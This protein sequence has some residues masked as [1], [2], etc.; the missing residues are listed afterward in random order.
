M[1][2]TISRTI[3]MFGLFIVM[4]LAVNVYAENIVPPTS[5][6]GIIGGEELLCVLENDP[7]HPNVMQIVS[8]TG[9]LST[10][11]TGSMDFK[12]SQH[13]VIL[14]DVALTG[15]SVSVA[16]KSTGEISF[17][18][19]GKESGLAYLFPHGRML[20]PLTLG[21]TL[22]NFYSVTPF[23][24]GAL[25]L[26][27][28]SSDRQKL[29]ATLSGVFSATTP[30]IGKAFLR[31]SFSCNHSK[32]KEIVKHAIP[33]LKRFT[34]V[35]IETTQLLNQALGQGRVTVPVAPDRGGIIHSEITV[36]PDEIIGEEFQVV[37]LNEMGEFEPLSVTLPYT[38]RSG[39]AAFTLTS[40]AAV[41]L[42]PD[43][44][45]SLSALEPLEL[46]LSLTDID[47]QEAY[48]VLS[49]FNHIVYNFTGLDYAVDV[50]NDVVEEPELVAE[51]EV[52]PS[53]IIVPNFVSL[54]FLTDKEQLER[55]GR[56]PGTTTVLDRFVTLTSTL[57]QFL[58]TIVGCWEPGTNSDPCVVNHGPFPTVELFT[59][60][61]PDYQFRF[62][63]V[64]FITD[65]GNVVLNTTDS[66]KLLE[67][68]K[69]PSIH[70]PGGHADLEHLI[71]GKLLNG[72]IIGMA[73]QPGLGQPVNHVGLSSTVFREHHVILADR[74]VPLQGLLGTLVAHEI[75]H[76]LGACHVNYTAKGTSRAVD[77]DACDRNQFVT[78][79]GRFDSDPTVGGRTGPEIMK[80]VLTNDI[81]QLYNLNND[82][83]IACVVNRF[84]GL[85]L[86]PGC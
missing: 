13:S 16:G 4:L 65:P 85:P 51:S 1:G 68:L 49:E 9:S 74:A 54:R 10:P 64:G 53:I 78:L 57:T 43:S 66:G 84:L 56:I 8:R 55:L 27:Q 23:N 15:S 82:F 24:S 30:V 25:L 21:A 40:D 7:E 48:L 14:E 60:H 17:S 67:A 83:R 45:A 71:T 26:A 61:N 81:I 42:I 80:P 52:A 28:L 33:S 63:W 59:D 70:P 20:L 18:L 36:E 73:N 29:H 62:K 11:L 76:N 47:Q 44:R 79:H 72:N 46:V 58:N 86:P 19:R 77:K 35:N 32:A 22:S 41:G 2:N 34:L 75:G 3:F 50:S 69:K 6:S 38:F 31:L 5:D 39:G 12:L 37:A